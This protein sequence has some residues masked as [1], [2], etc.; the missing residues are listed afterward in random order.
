M[1]LSVIKNEISITFLA[2]RDILLTRNLILLYGTGTWT[3]FFF[4][5]QTLKKSEN[6][7]LKYLLQIIMLK[8]LQ[9]LG[10]ELWRLVLVFIWLS[11]LNLD[12]GYRTGRYVTY[13]LYKSMVG[14][15]SGS[16]FEFPIRTGRNHVRKHELHFYL[17][18]FVQYRYIES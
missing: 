5:S 17:G 10:C 13:S 9:K 7:P 4:L 11:F 14:S 3:G 1:R 2:H 8:D 18:N 6:K 16:R 15:E 12:N